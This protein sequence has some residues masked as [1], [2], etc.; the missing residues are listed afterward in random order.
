MITALLRLKVKVRGQGH[1]SKV[2]VKSGNAVFL[3]HFHC[4]VPYDCGQN[5]EVRRVRVRV[6]LQKAVGGTSIF[7][8]GSFLVKRMKFSG[9]PGCRADVTAHS[10]GWWPL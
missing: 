10:G 4:P 1:T 8:Q 2:K 6:S 9:S 7:S 5:P 3:P